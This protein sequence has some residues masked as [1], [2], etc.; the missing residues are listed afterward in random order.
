MHTA[1]NEYAS[2]TMHCDSMVLGDLSAFNTDKCSS[3]YPIAKV[4]LLATVYFDSVIR[5][6]K[7]DKLVLR[8]FLCV[9]SPFA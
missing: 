2:K 4:Y 5:N 6:A 1:T 8:R 9:R 7:V 3:C